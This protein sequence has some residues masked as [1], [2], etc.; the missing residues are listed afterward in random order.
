MLDHDCFE[1][2]SD[3]L[4]KGLEEELM[5]KYFKQA[6]QSA[7]RVLGLCVKEKH[8]YADYWS[9]FEELATNQ[10][11]AAWR[12]KNA[13]INLYEKLFNDFEEYVKEQLEKDILRRKLKDD[14]SVL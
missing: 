13:Y 3:A 10:D 4:S 2:M 8:A 1:E 11:L 7:L 14:E 5:K 12:L 6:A 9:G